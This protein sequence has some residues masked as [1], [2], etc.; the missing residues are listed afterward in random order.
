M[1]GQQLNMCIFFSCNEEYNCEKEERATKLRER[2][3][4]ALKIIK[5]INTRVKFLYRKNG[6]LKNINTPEQMYK[7][8][9]EF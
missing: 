6:W 3:S 8:L 2:Q 7:F 4:L 1:S 5:K 9:F